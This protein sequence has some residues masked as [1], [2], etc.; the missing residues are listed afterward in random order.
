MVTVGRTMDS[1]IL[2]DGAFANP[3]Y[4]PFVAVLRGANFEY[5]WG[6]YIE[7][8]GVTFDEVAIS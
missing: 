7:L 2:F 4:Y 6:K 8:V 3:D 1:G 5:Q